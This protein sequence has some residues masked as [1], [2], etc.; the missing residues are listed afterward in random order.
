MNELC[1]HDQIKGQC[2]RPGCEYGVDPNGV[3]LTQDTPEELTQSD[4]NVRLALAWLLNPDSA[5]LDSFSED[6]QRIVARVTSK[7]PTRGLAPETEAL[8]EA[9]ERERVEVEKAKEIA[10]YNRAKERAEEIQAEGRRITFT[11]A[12]T[13]KARP[14]RWLWE[15]RMPI[16][17]ITLLAGRAGLGKST[18]GSYLAAQ[19]T[20][21][22]LSPGCFD[23]QPKDV[24]IFATEDA[25][26]YTI[27]PRLMAAGAEMSRIHRA[28]VMADESAVPFNAGLDADRLIRDALAARLDVGLIIF[29]PLVSVLPPKRNSGD[30]IRPVL[31]KLKRM[32]EQMNTNVLALVHFN[33]GGN[34]QSALERVT[35]TGEFGN[36]VRSG[37]GVAENKEDGTTVLSNIK[38]NL[39]PSGLPSIVYRID[40]TTVPTEEGPCSVGNVSILGQTLTTVEDLMQEE[41]DAGSRI[42]DAK[43]WLRDYLTEHGETPSGEV[44]KAAAKGEEGFSRSTVQRARKALNVQTRNLPVTPRVTTWALPADQQGL[45]PFVPD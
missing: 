26:E 5:R 11:N 32:A 34:N 45:R 41:S 4:I 14:V 36:V 2:R 17:E 39:A 16:G 44:L 27:V 20:N 9:H 3:R 24:L 22:T 38:H 7:L 8:I 43:T 23:G 28:D 42:S 18:F 13:I 12:S 29:D 1:Q 10:S 21:G 19:V 30:D 40:S 6:V 31:E 25:W 33:K 15:H 35:G 37:L